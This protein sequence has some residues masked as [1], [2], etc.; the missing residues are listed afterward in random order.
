MKFKLSPPFW[1]LNEIQ[2]EI[3]GIRE[4]RTSPQLYSTYYRPYS[5]RAEWRRSKVSGGFCWTC[6][7]WSY[8]ETGAQN[9]WNSRA[10]WK[11]H[12]ITTSILNGSTFYKSINHTLPHCRYR[13]PSCGSV[14]CDY[15][16]CKK[17]NRGIQKYFLRQVSMEEK[18]KNAFILTNV[19]NFRKFEST[20]LVWAFCSVLSQG[21]PQQAPSV[22]RRFNGH[23]A[24]IVAG[25]HYPP[26]GRITYTHLHKLL[27]I[28]QLHHLTVQKFDL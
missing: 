11:S 22:R 4:E 10:V 26:V 24:V 12:S 19:R 18:W 16:D 7:Q 28:P 1:V 2:N 6:N 23:L 21:L 15:T 20:R 25:G 14:L 17:N 8:S 5:C 9:R 3:S 27:Q 13:N